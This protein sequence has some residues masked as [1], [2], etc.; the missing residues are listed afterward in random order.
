MVGQL[1][2]DTVWAKKPQWCW[3]Q[4]VS[5]VSVLVA[6]VI[7]IVFE[8]LQSKQ[9]A[10]FVTERTVQCSNNVCHALSKPCRTV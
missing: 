10:C 7:G 3:L 5:L 2:A 4:A 6:L 1:L 9:S 8:M